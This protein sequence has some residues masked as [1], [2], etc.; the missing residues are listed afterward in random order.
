[1]IFFPSLDERGLR[2][3]CIRHEADRNNDRRSGNCRAA[4]ISYVGVDFSRDGLTRFLN[5][6]A[7]SSLDRW[8]EGVDL[9]LY[10]GPF[11]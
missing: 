11:H 7:A 6:L 8:S 2:G 10:R 4:V 1:M 9:P 3:G 5:R